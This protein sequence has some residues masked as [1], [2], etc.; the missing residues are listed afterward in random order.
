MN[1]VTKGKIVLAALIGTFFFSHP[2]L[3]ADF[4]PVWEKT[5]LPH[6]G[7]Y[8]DNRK[9][10]GNWTGGKVGKGKLLGTKYGIAASVYGERL[11]KEGILIKNLTK[12]QARAI[13]ERDY[14]RAFSF[15]KLASQGIATELCDETVNMGSKGSEALLRRVFAEI[16]WATGKPVPVRPQFYPETIAWI[17]QHTKDRHNRISFYNSIK[18]KR[19]KFYASLVHHRPAMKPFFVS[20]IDRSVD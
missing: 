7:G 20:W 13:Y 10:P 14:W 6:E 9:D 18:I 1:A 19:V 8:T 4:Q 3:S 11:R 17:N 5:I 15:D 16:E 2:A 12:D